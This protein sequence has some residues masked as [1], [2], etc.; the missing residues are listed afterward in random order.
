MITYYLLLLYLLLQTS[1]GVV[2]CVTAHYSTRDRTCDNTIF[3]L[4]VCY[5]VYLCY[6]HYFMTQN[7]HYWNL[8]GKFLLIRSWVI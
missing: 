1:L 6:L 2:I 5:C 3:S 4:C 8:F 7:S